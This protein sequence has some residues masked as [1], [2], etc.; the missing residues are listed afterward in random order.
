MKHSL[1]FFSLITVLLLPGACH[2]TQK[3]D[4]STFQGIIDNFQQRLETE[5]LKDTTGSLSAIVFIGNKIAWSHTFGKANNEKGID[6]GEHTVYRIGSISKTFT[7]WLMLLLVQD[8]TIRL[9]DPISKY[10]PEIKQLKRKERDTAEITFRE[11]AS[12]T[13]G[14]EREP[15][16]PNAATGPIDTWE[17]KVLNSIPT[18]DVDF[19][20][21]KKFSYSNI[22]YGILGLALSKAAHQ[23][24]MQMVE[25]RIFK[26]LGMTSSF[27]TIP[28]GYAD[29]VATGYHRNNFTQKPDGTL[30]TAEFTGRGYK[31]PNGGIFTTAG[32]L[33]RFIMAQYSDSTSLSKSYREMMQTIQT[34]ESGK[35]GYGFGLSVVNPGDGSKIVGHDGAVAG[36][37]AFMLFSPE[38]KVGAIVL[39]N[40]DYGVQPI[41]LAVRDVVQG[42]ARLAPKP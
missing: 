26:P 40:C 27:Y 5:H 22:G 30:A 32:D 2:N 9:D 25:D 23:P 8:G 42:L 6:A 28:A 4:T 36:Y 15:G 17:M 24:F 34:P 21:G 16:L 13:A 20:P 31:V 18:T 11:L 14:L 1:I 10:L 19:P 39:R 29:S 38:K 41:P 3:P 37:T 33:S 7:A 12:H 35:A